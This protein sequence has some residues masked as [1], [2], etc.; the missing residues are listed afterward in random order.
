MLFCRHVLQEWDREWDKVVTAAATQL[1]RNARVDG[2]SYEYLEEI[3]VFTLANVLRRPIIVLGVPFMYGRDGESI[4]QNN[5]VGIYLP[6]L[7]KPKRCHCMPIVIAF[8]VD[9]FQ[10][11]LLRARSSLSTETPL[12]LDAVPL[13]TADLEPLRIHFLLPDERGCVANTLLQQYLRTCEVELCGDGERQMVLCAYLDNRDEDEHIR[14]YIAESE[15]AS[16]S[17]SHTDTSSPQYGRHRDSSLH[18]SSAVSG[19]YRPNADCIV[20]HF[21]TTLAL[22]LRFWCRLKSLV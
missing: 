9:H 7:L 2:L 4:E 8:I 15:A 19:M 13:V 5:F 6:L 16:Q 22:R 10:P 3:H 1:Q 11:L 18:S 17:P 14:R 12:T 20:E 21:P